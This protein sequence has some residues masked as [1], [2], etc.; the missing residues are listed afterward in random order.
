MAEKRVIVWVQHCAD[1]PYLS[2]QWHDP[3]TGKRKRKSADTNNPL[4]AETKRSDL[5]Y[6]LNHGQYQEASR[7][8]W[9]HFREHFEAEYVPGTRK[10]TRRNYEATFDLFEK[11][12]NPRSL[13]GINERTI[14]L[15]V[16]G[17]RKEPGRRKGTE[18]MMPSSIKVR[19]QFLHTRACLGSRAKDA[20]GRPQVPR[21]QGAEEEPAAHPGGILRTLDRKDC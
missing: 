2:L 18:S 19:L 3:D 4:E 13:R 14:S 1:R 6:E 17:M 15:F 9:E 12:C 21:C 8:N 5:E 16:A 20:A 7:M 11:V 10:D